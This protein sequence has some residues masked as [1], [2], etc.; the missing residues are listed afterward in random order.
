MSNFSRFE[1]LP[2]SNRLIKSASR[3]YRCRATAT[4]RN[5]PLEH[6]NLASTRRF[7]RRPETLIRSAEQFGPNAR[8][9]PRGTGHTEEDCTAANGLWIP[10]VLERMTHV[11]SD[12]SQ[13]WGGTHMDAEAGEG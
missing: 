9:G 8:F 2:A 12:E 11:Y 1:V 3:T 5:R 6:R 13:Q 10:V 7:L 4:R